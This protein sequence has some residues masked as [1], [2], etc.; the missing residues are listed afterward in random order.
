MDEQ[1]DRQTQIT[2]ETIMLINLAQFTW[3]L[4]IILLGNIKGDSTVGLCK[5]VCHAHESV[6]IQ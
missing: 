1:N 2:T 5:R 6:T 4:D 3:E